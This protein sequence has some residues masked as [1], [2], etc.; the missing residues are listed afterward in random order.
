MKIGTA[1][2]E[3]E[4]LDENRAL[5]IVSVAFARLYRFTQC[6]SLCTIKIF[7]VVDTSEMGK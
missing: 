6:L 1:R 7:Y 4:G 2:I 3:L 5:F